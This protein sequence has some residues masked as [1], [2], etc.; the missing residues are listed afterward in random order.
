MPEIPSVHV[1]DTVTLVLFQPSELADGAATPLMLGAPVSILTV[2]LSLLVL[3][4]LSEIEHNTAWLPSPVIDTV[5][6]PSSPGVATGVPSVQTGSPARP[7]PVSLAM[8]VTVTGSWT[9]Q[10]WSPSGVC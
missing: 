1:N 8:M 5:H 6:V 2:S 10:P 7:E 3:P 9:F 4:A